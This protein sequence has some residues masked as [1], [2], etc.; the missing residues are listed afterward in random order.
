MAIPGNQVIN[1]GLPNEAYGSDT[2]YTAFHKIDNNFATL[3]ACASPY[4]TFTGTNGVSIT[5][6]A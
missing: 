4:T 5:T 3:F 1:I 2:L 6:N